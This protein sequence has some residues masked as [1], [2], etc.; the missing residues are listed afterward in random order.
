MIRHTIRQFAG[1]TGS[2]SNDPTSTPA[3]AI[4]AID[5]SAARLL[6]QLI[7]AGVGTSVRMVGG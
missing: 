6:T 1:L 5:F 3:V 4:S 2:Q 7:A